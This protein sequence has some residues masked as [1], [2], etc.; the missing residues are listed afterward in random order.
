M[1]IISG[2]QTGVDLAALEF[3]HTHGLPYGGWVPKGRTNEV[4]RIPDHLTGL[5]ETASEHVTDR[6]KRNILSSDATLVFTDGAVSPGTRQT[7]LF[8]KDAG[9]SH[10]VVD[11]RDGIDRCTDRVRGWLRSNS[12]AVLNVA[13]PRESEAP[14]LG[15][16]VREVMEHSLDQLRG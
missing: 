6:T 2:G 11:L 13:G 1:K 15:A 14:G 10:L 12:I 3:A 4:G 9:K 16:S 5:K 8:A 7:I